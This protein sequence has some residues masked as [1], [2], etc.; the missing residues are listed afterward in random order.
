MLTDNNLLTYIKTIEKLDA[1]GYRWDASLASYD[2]DL[3]YRS[4]K[5]NVDADSLSR[6]KESNCEMR[7]LMS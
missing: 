4:C 7:C 5:K 6:Q 2:F 3:K 1:T